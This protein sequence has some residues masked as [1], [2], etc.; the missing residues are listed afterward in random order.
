M[1]PANPHILTV[2]G[3]SPS[4]KSVLFEAGDSLQRTREGETEMTER[5]IAA[6]VREYFH[7]QNSAIGWKSKPPTQCGNKSL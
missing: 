2:N 6:K 1:K 5:Q 3:G 4:I 7:M